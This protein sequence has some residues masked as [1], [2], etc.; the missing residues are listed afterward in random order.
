[1][2]TL[3]GG[4]RDEVRKQRRDIWANRTEWMQ[5]ATLCDMLGQ[6]AHPNPLASLP[7]LTDL[8][9]QVFS[10]IYD[11]LHNRFDNLVLVSKAKSVTVGILARRSR[12]IA[13]PP[14]PL[15]LGAIRK[16]VEECYTSIACVP[17]G[18][19]RMWEK[20]SLS[21]AATPSD[22]LPSILDAIVAW[23]VHL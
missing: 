11:D 22:F 18:N 7:F 20:A 2:V 16:N 14:S 23:C 1:M 10:V 9:V 12:A 5:V 8:V 19:F 3:E 4:I 13:P 6:T 21:F 15:A 17:W